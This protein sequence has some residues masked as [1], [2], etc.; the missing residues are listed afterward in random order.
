MTEA[1]SQSPPHRTQIKRILVLRWGGVGDFLLTLPAIYSVRRHFR[2]AHLAIMGSADTID[3]A[4]STEYAD[5]LLPFEGAISSDWPEAREAARLRMMQ[6]VREF[7]LVI[8]YHPFARVD[9]LLVESG[10]NYVNFADEVFLRERKHASEH[11]CDFVRSITAAPVF[12]RPKVYLSAGERQFA[13]NFLNDHGFVLRNNCVVAVHVG[14]GDPRKR[15]F[16]DRYR[17]V[18]G[19]LV[20]GGAKV[21]LLAGPADDDIVRRVY[22][23]AEQAKVFIVR[24]FPIRKVAAILERATL[25]L[26]NDSG[27]MH[28][29]AAVGTPVV[30][31]F[32]PSDPVTWGPLGPRNVIVMGHC[33]GTDVEVEACR[34]CEFQACLDSIQTAEVIGVVRER[35]RYLRSFLSVSCLGH[36]LPCRFQ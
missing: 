13:L 20:A 2:H 34:L 7:D 10:V 32:G 18:I 22:E 15:W 33:P 24:E 14:S 19:S 30:A 28:L 35:L 1:A 36:H 26:G 29:A 23:G 21:L 5:E 12:S 8:N 3:L 11:F 31:L 27:L 9:E 25:F 16:P 17:E 4:A 6:Q